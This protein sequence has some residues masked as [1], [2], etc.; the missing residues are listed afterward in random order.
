MKFTKTLIASAV[1]LV[2]SSAFAATDSTD[3]QIN[4]TKDAFVNLVGSAVGST[5]SFTTDDIDASTVSLGTLGL[6]SNS[7]GDCDMTFASA[8]AFKLINAGSGNDLGTYSIKYAGATH[9]VGAANTHTQSCNTVA[10]AFELESPAMPATVDAGVY[11]DT[12]TVTVVTQ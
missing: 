2:T 3:I 8:N 10:S 9:T 11:S 4:V 6:E 5:N 1:F 7:A 12:V